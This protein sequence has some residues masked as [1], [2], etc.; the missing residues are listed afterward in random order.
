MKNF[1]KIFFCGISKVEDLEVVERYN[2]GGILL[3][4]PIF[5][6]PS[7]FLHVINRLEGKRILLCTDHE[8][9]QIEII[10][11]I[12]PSPGNL[13]LGKTDEKTVNRYC[14]FAGKIMK[15]LGLN[16]VFAPVLDLYCATSN[17]VIGYRS[18]G[19]DSSVV[20]KMGLAAIEGYRISG[21]ASC[22]KHFPGHGRATQDSH[23]ELAIVDVDYETLKEDLYPFEVAIKNHVESIMLAHVIYP[24]LDDKP[25]SISTRIIK[26]LLREELKYDGL[27]ISDA[28]EMKALSKICSPSEVIE[29][30]INAGGD[31][32][33]LSSPSSLQLY[34][35]ELNRLLQ[36]GRLDLKQLN[37][38]VDRVESLAKPIESDIEFLHDS[39]DSSVEF[40]ISNLTAKEIVFILP[41]SVCFSQA[42]VSHRYLPLIKEQVQRLLGARVVEFDD[43]ERY[44]GSLLVDFIIDL[45]TDEI[46]THRELSKDFNV[47]Y[48]LTRNASL[49]KYFEDLN[50]IVTYSLSPLVTGMVFRKLSK[51]LTGGELRG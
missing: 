30:F 21:I 34:A 17:S 14:T 33:I 43:L 2:V 40:H 46:N 11:Y 45:S 39:I 44:R 26:N 24:A 32:L 25:A 31:M 23:E 29:K 6:D 48:L 20:A 4:S 28:V 42:D 10:P 12:F 35:Q 51:L 37:R 7:D 36:E 19:S 16:M 38:A 41:K 3:H 49:K 22:A 9:G 27:I 15:T 13:L 47:I 8:G 18:Y 50:H 5:R 1:E